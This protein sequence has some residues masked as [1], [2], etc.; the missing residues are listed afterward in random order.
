MILDR[1]KKAHAYRNGT[2]KRTNEIKTA[3]E[4]FTSKIKTITK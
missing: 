2:I 1:K 4:N 3:F